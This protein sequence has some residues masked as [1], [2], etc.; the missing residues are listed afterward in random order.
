M[1]SIGYT[2]SAQ[3]E[4]RKLDSSVRRRV[5]AAIDALAEDPRP[6][7]CKKMSGFETLWRIRIG[8]YRVVYDVI[9]EQVIVTVVRVAHRREAYRS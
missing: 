2:T 9:D 6:N 5:R 4:L 3:R 8:D 7:G 1:Y